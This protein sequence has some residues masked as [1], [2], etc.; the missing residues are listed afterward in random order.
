MDKKGGTHT[1]V[2]L[3]PDKEKWHI[4]TIPNQKHFPD[5]KPLIIDYQK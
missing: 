4:S 2:H 1:K 5:F 3:D